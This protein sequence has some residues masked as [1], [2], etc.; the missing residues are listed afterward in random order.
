MLLLLPVPLIAQT[1]FTPPKSLDGVHAR[2]RD[3]VQVLED[4]LKTV[5]AATARVQRDLNTASNALLQSRA[6]AVRDGCQRSVRSVAPIRTAIAEAGIPSPD[7]KR[8]RAEIQQ[9]LQVLQGNLEKCATEFDSL[10]LPSQAATMKGYG[11]S[12][13]LKVNQALSQYSAVLQAY[14]GA[15]EVRLQ[16]KAGVR[17]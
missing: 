1:V 11:P 6:R 5:T 15:I 14:L 8:R 4:S 2:L 3:A 16:P 13:A 12:R 9:A 10:A 17:E 7:P